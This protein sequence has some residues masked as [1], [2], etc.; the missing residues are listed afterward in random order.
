MVGRSPISRRT[1]LLALGSGAVGATTVQAQDRP[2]TTEENNIECTFYD[3]AR[4]EVDA[5]H[6]SA[7]NTVRYFVRY[8][9]HDGAEVREFEVSYPQYP[10]EFVANCHLNDLD[11]AHGSAVIERVEVWH[12]MHHDATFHPPINWSCEMVAQEEVDPWVLEE[13]C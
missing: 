9:G 1:V 3:C 6:Q 2:Y 13:F 11:T 4:V 12:D 7:H 8:N 5:G 10:H